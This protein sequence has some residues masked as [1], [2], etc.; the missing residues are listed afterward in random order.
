MIE[1]RSPDDRDHAPAGRSLRHRIPL[2]LAVIAGSTMLVLRLRGQPWWCRCGR[3]SP[4]AGDIW[5]GHNSQHLLDPYSLSHLLHGL[6]FYALLRP[7]AGRSSWGTRLVLATAL[8]AAWELA[9]NSQAVIGRYRSVT[10]AL[11]YAGD[12][13]LNSLGD[14]SSCGVGFLL[15]SRLPA[16]LSVALF[17]LVEVGMLVAYRDC[18]LLNVVMLVYPIGAVRTWQVG[19]SP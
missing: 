15:A 12:S 19:L 3:A 14:I 4:W 5:S 16:R 2:A 8:E 7:L 11:G 17:V 1:T 9:E 18:F 13:L 6:L 10:L